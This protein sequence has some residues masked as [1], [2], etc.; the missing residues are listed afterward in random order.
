MSGALLAV[1]ETMAVVTP[2]T[3][4]PVRDAGTFIVDAGGA[5]SNVAAHVAALGHESRW[6]S[7]LGDDALGARIRDQLDRRGVDTSGV[8]IDSTRPTGLYLKDPGHGVVYYRSGSAASACDVADAAGV[9]WDGV[10]V[11]HIT[12]ITAA[13]SSTA[14]EF[15]DELIVRARAAGAQVS[16]DVNHRPVLWTGRDAAAP[17]DA[18][19]RQADI[20]FVGRDEAEALW[21][22]ATAEAIRDRF[23]LTPVLVVKDAHIGATAFAGTT[24]VFEPSARVD[25]VD[26]VGAGDAFAG[27]FLAATLAGESIADRLRHGHARAALTLRTA[28]DSV[29]DDDE[30]GRP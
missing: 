12:G 10:A 17:L 14:A 28:G 24:T 13:L 19:A 5:E 16:V 15:L 22:E 2:A 1:G 30:G 9:R 7:R 25:V 4:D 20:L 8:V 23:P 18:L 27:G 6:V 29:T 3:G 21:G 11:L 26:A